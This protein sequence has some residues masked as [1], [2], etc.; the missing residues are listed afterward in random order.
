MDADSCL[1]IDGLVES[2][3]DLKGCADDKALRE[4]ASSDVVNICQPFI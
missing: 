4:V 3:W 1:P 2:L